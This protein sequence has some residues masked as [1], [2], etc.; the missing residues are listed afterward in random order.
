MF[1]TL[2]VSHAEALSP[3]SL[4]STSE[5]FSHTNHAEAERL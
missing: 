5:S 2:V 4:F 3:V 1:E